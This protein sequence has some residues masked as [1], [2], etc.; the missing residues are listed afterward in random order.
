MKESQKETAALQK[1][2]AELKAAIKDAEGATPKAGGG[3]GGKE[4]PAEDSYDDWS[5][6]LKE[7]INSRGQMGRF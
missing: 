7:L 2:V 5:D 4:T 6:E 1:E 3:R